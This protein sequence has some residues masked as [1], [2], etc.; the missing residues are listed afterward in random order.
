[1]STGYID[2]VA[3]LVWG[4]TT[5]Q[6]CDALGRILEK[7]Q[8]W[9]STHASIFAPNKFQLTHFTRS[10]KRINTDMPIQTEWGEIKPKA[11]CRYLGLTM[12]AKL[13]WKEHVEEI[14]RKATKTVSA[15]SCLGGSNWGAGLMDMR[16]IYEGTALPQM[17]YAC[18]I[19]SNASIKGRLYTKKTLRTLQSIQARAARA[20]CGAYKATSRAALDIESF[21]LPIE[22][23]MW[24]HS[25]DIVTRLFSSMDIVTT[26]GF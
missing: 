8:R 18:S 20:I 22:Q 19:W 15:I 12:D 16:R 25:A 17:M 4:K 21:L 11:T 10:L 5:E 2:D 7:A 24:R 6:T 13:H 23:Q 26:A 3:I 14:R 1:M 9:A